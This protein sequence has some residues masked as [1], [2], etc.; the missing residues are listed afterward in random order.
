M[1]T[2]I[3]EDAELAV[4]RGIYWLDENHPNWASQIDLSQLD[5]A[6]CGNCVIGQ[7]VGDYSRVTREVV[8]AHRGDYETP[9]IWAVEHGFESPTISIYRSAT[10]SSGSSATYDYEALDT[11]WSEEVRKRLG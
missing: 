6:E 1:D 9:I 10:G 4:K 7:A 8:Q 11:L 5:M 2:F 3:N